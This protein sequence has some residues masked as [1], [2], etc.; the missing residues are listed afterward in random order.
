MIRRWSDVDPVRRRIY[1]CGLRTVPRDGRCTAD[2]H[3]QLGRQSGSPPDPP[4]VDCP[5]HI[6]TQTAYT[7]CIQGHWDMLP[8]Q[9]CVCNFN[10]ALTSKIIEEKKVV[11]IV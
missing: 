10:R 2:E 11:V 6:D 4:P 7:Q 3:G 9:M 5:L 1:T 8:P